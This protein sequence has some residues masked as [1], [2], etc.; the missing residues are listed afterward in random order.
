MTNEKDTIKAILSGN[1]DAYRSLVDRYQTGL[2]I[3]CD[4]LVRDRDAA[5]DLAQDA[6]VKAYTSLRTFDPD[7]AAFSTWLYRIA[8]NVCIDH[9]RKSKRFVRQAIEDAPMQESMTEAEINHIRETVAR[10]TPP[11]YRAVI[12]AYFWEGK[13]YAQIAATHNTTTGTV[14]TWI[15]RAKAQLRKELA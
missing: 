9:L 10:L 3:Y 7:R 6:F 15:S 13:T 14:G 11:E 12:E 8:S 2:I 4:Q 5:E 1:R